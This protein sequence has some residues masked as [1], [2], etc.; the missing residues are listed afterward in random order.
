M[1]RRLP[2]AAG[3]LVA[4]LVAGGRSVHAQGKGPWATLAEGARA[5]GAVQ[6]PADVGPASRALVELGVAAIPDLFGFLDAGRI[7]PRQAA[8]VLLDPLRRATIECALGRFPHGELVRFLGRVARESSREHERVTGLGL[9]ERAGERADLVLCLE[10]GTPAG[11][12][13]PGPELR[14]ALAAALGALVERENAALGDLCGLFARTTPVTRSV[15]LDVVREQAGPSSVVRLADLL[16]RAGNEADALVLSALARAERPVTPAAAASALSRVRRFLSHSDHQLASL[17]CRAVEEQRDHEAVPDLIALLGASNS[18]LGASAHRALR[19]L[20][21]LALPADLA[22][23]MHWLDASLSWWEEHAEACRESIRGSDPVAAADAIADVAAQRLHLD[24]VVELLVLA[25][26]R[27]EADQVLVACRALRTI[28]TAGAG[29]AL[30]SLQDHA[31]P[32]VAQ[33]ARAAVL[34]RRAPP[35]TSSRRLALSLRR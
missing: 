27:P 10:L 7:E 11:G 33:A 8:P 16:G 28:P 30:E 6:A 32:R 3:T 24:A 9:L 17:A 18:G 20:T 22:T 2:L 31:D 29:V 4:I 23:W 21:G 15:L 14:S 1:S 25:L 34:E 5:V 19:G 35:P 12:A 26:Q 13:L